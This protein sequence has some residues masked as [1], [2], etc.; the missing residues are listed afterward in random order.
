MV[1]PSRRLLGLTFDGKPIYEPHG[2][3]SAI[4][5]AAMGGGKTTCAAVPA[6]QSMLIDTEQAL[7]INDVKNGEIAAQIAEMCI[8]HGRKFA[9]VDD[10]HVLGANYPHRV[11]LNPFSAAQAAAQSPAGHLPF[12]ID[13]AN[14]A[15][16]EEPDNDQKNFYWRESPRDFLAAATNILLWHNARLATPGGLSAFLSDPTTWKSALEIEAA[17]PDSPHRNAATRLLDLKKLNP[18]HYAQ[19]HHAAIS[20]LKIF[21]Y[22]PLDEAGR[23][24]TVTHEQLVREHYVVCF[25]NP[26]RY[27]DRLGPYFAQHVLS[28]MQAQMSGTVGRACWI[29]DEFCN[30]PLREA[31]NRVTAFRAFGLRCL[32]I[33]QS[34]LDSVRRYG[35]R[36]T[37]VLEENC[38]VKQWLKFSNFEEAERVSKAMGES[39][40]V[41]HGL[42]VNSDRAGYSGSL[43]IGRDRLFTPYELMSL[44]GDEQIIHVADVGFIHAKKIRQNEIA[45]YCFELAD[46]PLEGGRLKP[47]PKVHL[48]TS[49]RSGS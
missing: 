41:S 9:V 28:L 12:I 14:Y 49:A 10:F 2:N 24:A 8:K 20:A 6:I 22:P 19:H 5:Y 30:A 18:E 32:Y 45:P 17:D 4:I 43:S 11:S 44:P 35:E 33:T 26:I 21:A 40:N 47:N 42:G 46:N 16:I 31:V 1:K 13:S 15:L 48:P 3:A 39:L 25:V 7:L 23:T 34:R 27:A 37:A 38:A 36:E 29:L